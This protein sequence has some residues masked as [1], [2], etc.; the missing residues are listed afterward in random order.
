M[1]SLVLLVA[2]VLFNFISYSTA[3][4]F[5]ID[6]ETLKVPTSTSSTYFTVNL[7]DIPEKVDI[8]ELNTSFN[9]FFKHISDPKIDPSI[10]TILL[11]LQSSY[12]YFLTLLS[13]RKSYFKDGQSPVQRPCYLDI[14][15]LNPSLPS[16]IKAMVKLMSSLTPSTNNL[17]NTS[18][19]AT[20]SFVGTSTFLSVYLSTIQNFLHEESELIT[21]LS[22]HAVPDFFFT[23]FDNHPCI[24]PS[25]YN[26]IEVH[27]FDIT[28]KGPVITFDIKQIFAET[29]YTKIVPVPF[30]NHILDIGVDYNSLVRNNHGELI[31]LS[32]DPTGYPCR[33][34]PLVSDCINNI[35]N[36]FRQ[37]SAYCTLIPSNSTPRST[38]S[39]I[40][41]PASS[42]LFR[43]DANTIDINVPSLLTT[44]KQV[45]IK[46]DDE[47]YI[48]GPTSTKE[49][50]I[51]SFFLNLAESK[52]LLESI[53][54]PF[55]AYVP[56]LSEKIVF[57]TSTGLIF[58]MVSFLAIFT[59]FRR[60]SDGNHPENR[61]PVVF[62]LSTRP[63]A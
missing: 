9:T 29:K 12:K 3:I 6:D 52:Q 51:D 17:E 50:K 10:K 53:L 54:N 31:S 47:T 11:D 48:F 36:D 8:T 49:F 39:G 28:I 62:R 15:I 32:C 55:T 14:S 40:L 20:Q 57:G 59:K 30:F 58:S 56:T 2:L 33:E 38:T 34:T 22:R 18:E 21:E 63:L 4:K 7:L 60:P 5:F 27:N 26:R 45:K 25:L 46:T 13:K 16:H 42:Q 61:H 1:K 24:K 37:I 23:L 41:I 43:E 44:P 19:L 35:N